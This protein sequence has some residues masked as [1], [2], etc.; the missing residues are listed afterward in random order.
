MME[1]Q[2]YPQDFEASWPERRLS[3][4]PE[5]RRRWSRSPKRCTGPG[6]FGQHRA[7]KGSAPKLQAGIIEQCDAQ[8]GLKDGIIQDPPSAHFDCPKCQANRRAAQC[9]EAIF[10]GSRNDKG[11]IYPG[12]A[13]VAECV[14]EQWIAWLTGPVPAFA[15]D[16]V[17]SHLCF[18]TQIFK[19][20]VLQSAG[21]DYSTYDFS[22]FERDARLP[23]LFS[24]PPT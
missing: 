20:L 3:T 6:A 8:D 24:M 2:R 19:Y 14:P 18:R 7:D 15:K 11:P 21:L 13:P 22:N 10:Q 4:G 9:I 17:R 12:F 5:L 16:H 23:P 1:A